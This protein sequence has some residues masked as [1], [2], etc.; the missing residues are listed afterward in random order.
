[1]K[2]I[3]VIAV[4]LTVGVLF[5][6]CGFEDIETNTSIIVTT[7]TGQQGPLMT[8]D[9]SVDPGS[10]DNE[11]SENTTPSESD[12]QS[13]DPY[14]SLYRATANVNA[15]SG[16]S[17]DDEIVKVVDEGTEL[18][19]TGKQDNWYIVE[20]DGVVAYIIEDYLEGENSNEEENSN[21]SGDENAVDLPSE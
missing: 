8:P 11:S 21:A 7:T 5:S 18:T 9:S 4:A 10:S 1:M 17:T 20:I 14:P 2:F 3:R 19:V 13:G 12:D 15:R 6:G 16:P